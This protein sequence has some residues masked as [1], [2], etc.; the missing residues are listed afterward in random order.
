MQNHLFGVVMNTVLLGDDLGIESSADLKQKLAAYVSQQGLLTLDAGQ[1]SRIHTASVQVLC[2]FV[3]AR[4]QAGQDT[5]F[6]GCNDIFRDAA[7]LLGVTA[8]LGLPASSVP[9]KSV[10]HSA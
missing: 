10:E 3:D 9:L 1:V 8:T 5:E 2:A 4:R 6:D 7:R